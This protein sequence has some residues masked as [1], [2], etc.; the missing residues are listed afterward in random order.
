[1]TKIVV[2]DSGYGGELFADALE[3]EFTAYKIIR[4]IDWRNSSKI[5]KSAKTAR[6]AALTSLR[7]YIGKVDLIVFANYLLSLT[8]LNYFRKKFPHQKFV[9]FVLPNL[10]R[11]STHRHRRTLVLST[12]AL[13][14]S[15]RFKLYLLRM[16]RFGKLQIANLDHWVEAIDDGELSDANIERSMAD[17]QKFQP[18]A[19]VLACT[20]FIEIKDNLKAVFEKR[21]KGF[22]YYTPVVSSIRSSLKIFDYQSKTSGLRSRQNIQKR[23]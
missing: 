9:G 19:I 2:Y 5:I 13:S 20:Q 16:R 10:R 17:Y 1:M 18:N 15:L 4:V 12:E 6:Q 11:L 7:P 14:K 22:D 3:E 23:V 8:S 21:F